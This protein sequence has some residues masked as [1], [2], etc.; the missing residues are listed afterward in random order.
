MPSK[1]DLVLIAGSIAAVMGWIERG[2]SVV[3][4]SPDPIELASLAPAPACSENDS[5]RYAMSQMVFSG[6]GFVSGALERPSLPE[7]R[8]P[9]CDTKL[10]EFSAR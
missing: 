8:S 2:H 3:I 7:A 5:F 10:I 1:L 9:A 6:D 4:D